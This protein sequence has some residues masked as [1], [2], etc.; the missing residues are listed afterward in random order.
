LYNSKKSSTFA[1][2]FKSA[3]VGLVST[4]CTI[5]K[6]KSS[7]NL[8]RCGSHFL[9]FFS[10]VFAIDQVFIFSA[11]P[12]IRS[13]LRS[14]LCF[15]E[16]DLFTLASQLPTVPKSLCT[17]HARVGYRLRV[18]GYR[19]REH[20][21]RVPKR[22][23]INSPPLPRPYSSMYQFFLISSIFGTC[24]LRMD[25]YQFRLITHMPY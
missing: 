18:I 21:K 14:W 20:K 25:M 13:S 1:A 10:T 17:S 22:C 6:V 7:H 19:L 23:S 11:Y 24:L 16:S 8:C 5:K 15:I 3:L 4:Y 9:F 2:N 12:L